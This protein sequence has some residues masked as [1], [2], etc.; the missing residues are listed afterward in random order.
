MYTE[1]V[2]HKHEDS[3]TSNENYKDDYVHAEGQ[4]RGGSGNS[5]RSIQGSYYV[6]YIKY[7]GDEALSSV[8]L[9]SLSFFHRL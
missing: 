4:R 8:R 1:L 2:V 6:G 3:N 9:V 7:Q 5:S